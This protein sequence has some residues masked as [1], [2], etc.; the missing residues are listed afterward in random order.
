MNR[1]VLGWV[2]VL[3][4][5]VTAASAAA[6]WLIA[7]G[8]GLE[9]NLALGVPPLPS[10]LLGASSLLAIVSSIALIRAELPPPRGHMRETYIAHRTGAI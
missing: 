3:L 6:V 9:V 7:A 10:L 2:V 8:G 1:I 4:A 5:S